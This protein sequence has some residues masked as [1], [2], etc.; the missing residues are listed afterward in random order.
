MVL[1]QFCIR[2]RSFLSLCLSPSAEKGTKRGAKDL[3]LAF[4]LPP[5]NTVRSLGSAHHR[6]PIVL[7]IGLGASAFS[8]L[9][10][11]R[12]K[13]EVVACRLKGQRHPLFVAVPV[14]QGDHHPEI[15]WK[16]Q[17]M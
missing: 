16:V 13:E 6:R 5:I 3:A 12:R 11:C 2:H 9:R 1:C 15:P 7:T 10:E 17:R 4:V 8:Y 14:V